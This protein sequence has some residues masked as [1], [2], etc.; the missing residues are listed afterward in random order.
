MNRICEWCNYDSR[1]SIKLIN[2]L[3]WRIAFYGQSLPIFFFRAEGV[4]IIRKTDSHFG[5]EAAYNIGERGVERG[6][7]N[8]VHLVLVTFLSSRTACHVN[9]L[10]ATFRQDV[11][12]FLFSPQYRHQVRLP[13]RP[14]SARPWRVG[15]D[16]QTDGRTSD[17]IR[18]RKI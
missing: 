6:W 14:A 3:M 18:Q 13:D 17:T 2:D 9:L 16:G 11:S 12:L 15:I 7:E 10:L 1:G 5:V 8:E 4:K